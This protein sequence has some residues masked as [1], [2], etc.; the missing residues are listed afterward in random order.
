M[1]KIIFILSLGLATGFFFGCAGSNSSG[2]DNQEQTSEILALDSIN[3]ELEK[4]NNNLQ[5]QAEAVEQSLDTLL[6][7]N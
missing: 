5:K 7:D 4:V 2:N 1:K 3:S 6:E